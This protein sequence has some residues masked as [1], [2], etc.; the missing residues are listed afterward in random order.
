LYNTSS[1]VT[2]EHAE[3]RVRHRIS[4]PNAVQLS[5]GRNGRGRCVLCL[6]GQLRPIKYL[7]ALTTIT[8]ARHVAFLHSIEQFHTRRCVSGRDLIRRK[9]SP[10]WGVLCFEERCH[11]FDSL[12]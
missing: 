4:V 7:H 2:G 5:L 12:G 11:T 10:H 6:P 8:I 1:V 3:E 9:K